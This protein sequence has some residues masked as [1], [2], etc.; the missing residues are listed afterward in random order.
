MEN[1]QKISV[2]FPKYPSD[3]DAAKYNFYYINYINYFFKNEE[4]K[5]NKGLKHFC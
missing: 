4:Y 1:E 3:L 2:H 5:M